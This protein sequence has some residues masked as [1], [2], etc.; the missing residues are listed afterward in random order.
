M[1]EKRISGQFLRKRQTS[2]YRQCVQTTPQRQSL[3]LQAANA[4]D[5]CTPNIKEHAKHPDREASP[6]LRMGL[7]W[8]SKGLQEQLGKQSPLTQKRN[9]ETHIPAS[10]KKTYMN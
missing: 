4:R 10:V 5:Q 8:V 9:G 2:P 1:V 6:L 7:S 3:S